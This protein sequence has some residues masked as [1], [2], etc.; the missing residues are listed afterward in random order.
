MSLICFIFLLS[1]SKTSC[2][3][4]GVI[5]FSYPKI[6]AISLSNTVLDG[7]SEIQIDSIEDETSIKEAANFMVDSFWLQS[8]QQLTTNNDA[9]ISDGV[10]QS[11]TNLQF[12]DLSDKYGERM[13][14]RVLQ[15]C[16]LTAKDNQN[17][18][19]IIGLEVCLLNKQT[20]KVLS[21]E[22]SENML[23]QAVASLGPKQRRQY[24]NSPASELATELLPPELQLVCCLSNLSTSPN[25]RRLGLGV[26]LCKEVEDVAKGFGFE[27][28]FLRVE[29]ENVAARGLYDKLGYVETFSDVDALGLRVDGDSGTFVEVTAETLVMEKVL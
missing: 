3:H 5:P 22:T 21:A 19:G 12:Q 4:T 14:K 15:S 16:L 8:P 13:G 9:S 26:K 7:S 27:S 17:I 11:L 28:L 1:L 25:A 24:K 2:F 18:L 6:T 23:K 20:K 29:K 10:K